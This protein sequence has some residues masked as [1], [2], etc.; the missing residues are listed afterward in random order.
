MP[1][2]VFVGLER[3]YYLDH[4]EISMADKGNLN[5]FPLTYIFMFW[6]LN[7][8]GNYLFIVCWVLL[9]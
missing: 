5:H 4:K 8:L 6:N 9:L 1:F 7:R 2:G 3:L